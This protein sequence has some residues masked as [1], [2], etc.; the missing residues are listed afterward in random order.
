MKIHLDSASTADIE[1]A[2]STGLIDGIATDPSSLARESD[3]TDPRAHISRLARLTD[4]P[5]TVEVVAVDAAEM[6]REGKELAK[7]ADNIVVRIPMIE[8][9]IVA[10]RRLAIDGVRVNTTLIFT[11]AQ[12]LLAAKAGA[13]FVSPFIGRL[14]DIGHDGLGVLRDIR[15]VFDRFHFDCEVM[16][17]SVRSPGHFIE[18]AKV[19]ADIAAVPVDVLRSLLLHPLTDRGLDQYLSDWSKRGAKA[20]SGV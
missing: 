5:V 9:G 6:Y 17:E 12:A 7:L 18:C 1:W 2:T 4:G 15:E 10:I 19:G 8:E 16:V 13:A 3:E 14:D 20:R 11:A